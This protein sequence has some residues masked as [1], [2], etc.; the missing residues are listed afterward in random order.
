MAVSA[1]YGDHDRVSVDHH[2]PAGYAEMTASSFRRAPAGLLGVTHRVAS[3]R[4]SW[5]SLALHEKR[6]AGITT[7]N[8]AG[9]VLFV[10]GATLSSV[11]FDIPVPGR[12]WMDHL[13][14][15]GF[16]VFALDVRGYGQSSRPAAMDAPPANHP[17]VARARDVIHDIDDAVSFIRKTANRTRIDLIGGSWGSVT[18]GLYASTLGSEWIERLVLYAPLFSARNPG[19]L[20]WI[21]DPQQ[22]GELHPD[23]G[24]YR[25][26]TV[27]ANHS[28]WLA[29]LDA[30]GDSSLLEPATFDALMRA[31][32][33]TDTAARRHEP[34]AVRVPN[35]TLADLLEVFTE[36]PLYKPEDIRCP[37]LLLRGSNDP[38]ST[39]AD[40]EGLLG[41]LGASRASLVTVAPGTHFVSAEVHAPKVY[42]AS[43]DFLTRDRPNGN[44]R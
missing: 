14:A 38:T 17:P 44:F 28:R 1:R 19:W 27:E 5:L 43:L 34:P 21:E 20:D 41:R 15:A 9:C 24:A 2:L 12:S 18:T 3:T 36:R 7:T 8:A 42:A 22:P 11:L 6:L 13:A 37:V 33:T 4:E 29:E 31:F 39:R 35:G 10:H 30:A 23:I 25:L 32:L 26:V 40:A 16:I